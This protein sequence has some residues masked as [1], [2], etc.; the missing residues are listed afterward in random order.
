MVI[1]NSINI[2]RSFDQVFEMRFVEEGA[3][4]HL[5]WESRRNEKLSIM[6]YIHEDPE[7]FLLDTESV[8]TS[9]ISVF[10]KRKIY[11]ISTYEHEFFMPAKIDRYLDDSHSMIFYYM[12]HIYDFPKIYNNTSRLTDRYKKYILAS[13]R[14]NV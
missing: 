7:E 6:D 4:D 11:P 3:L 14:D 13:R 9:P 1:V 5:S 10:Q 2:R 8:S 12:T